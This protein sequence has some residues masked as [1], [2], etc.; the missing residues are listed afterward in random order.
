MDLEEKL[1]SVLSNPDMMQKIAAMAQS[2]N[3]QA[4]PTDTPPTEAPKLSPMPN[5]DPAMLQRVSGMMNGMGVDSNQKALLA[6]LS[7]YLA[8]D[9]I[10]KLENAMRAAK[11]A[12]IAASV[13][14]RKP[15]SPGR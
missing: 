13:V 14:Q 11:M 4:K 10:Q 9:R 5:I 2:L 6:A 3:Q 8:R 7:P 15:T 1:N 12:G